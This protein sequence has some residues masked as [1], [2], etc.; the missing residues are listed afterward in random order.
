MKDKC[1]SCK[2]WKNSQAELEY[3][4]IHG[5]CTCYKWHFTI[6]NSADVMILDRDNKS[7]VHMSVHRFENQNHQVPIGDRRKSRYCFV[8]EEEFG[9]IHHEKR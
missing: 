6:G 9:C 8:T 7:H 5:I 4:N 3:S 2:H 1:K